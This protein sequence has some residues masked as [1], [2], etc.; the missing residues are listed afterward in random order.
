MS[1][2]LCRLVLTAHVT[3][4]VG[5]L[6]AVVVFLVLAIVGLVGGDALV[7]RAT[8]VALERIGWLAIVPLC[9][10]SLVTGVIQGLGTPWGLVR[11]YWVFIKLV[12]AVIASGLLILHMRPIGHLASVAHVSEVSDRDRAA[13]I[14][15]LADAALALLALLAATTLSVYKPRSVT[16]YGRRHQPGQ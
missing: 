3:C 7:V 15:I 5:W 4:S 14:Q 8:Y 13:Q 1:P 10:G 12:I 16:S 2:G 6:G 11:H 9:F